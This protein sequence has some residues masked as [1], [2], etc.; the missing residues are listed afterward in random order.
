MEILG[1]LDLNPKDMG[2]WSNMGELEEITEI[3]MR[4]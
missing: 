3:Y 1:Q 2:L 4:I